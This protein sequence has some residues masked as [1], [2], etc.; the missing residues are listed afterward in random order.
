[1]FGKQ[2]VC[3]FSSFLD[4]KNLIPLS[5]RSKEHIFVN[6]LPIRGASFRNTDYSQ[7]HFR[8]I[9]LGKTKTWDKW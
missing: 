6:S 7:G 3:K 5:N 1:M 4:N 2:I 9:L 8:E